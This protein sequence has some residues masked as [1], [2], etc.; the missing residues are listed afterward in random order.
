MTSPDPVT[1]TLPKALLQ[2]F[3]AAAAAAHPKEACGLLVGW[4]EPDVV[5]V[6]EIH[7]SPNR[8]EDP[9][10]GFEID[11]GLQAHLQRSLRGTDSMLVGVWHSHPSGDA[12]P[13][14]VDSLAAHDPDFVWIITAAV[15]GDAVTTVQLAP[16]EAGDAFRPVAVR[17][18]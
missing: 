9:T 6:T 16:A 10:Q 17:Y 11:V 4:W 7:Y 13:S 14:E 18:L 12:K 2:S 1:V 8:A 15:E 3:E 5:H